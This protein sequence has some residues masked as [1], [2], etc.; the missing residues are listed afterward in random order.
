[1]CQ[2]GVDQCQ[3]PPANRVGRL[4]CNIRKHHCFPRF[5]VR[6]A[7]FI[8]KLLWDKPFHFIIPSAFCRL[9]AAT[10]IM[11]Y[12]PGFNSIQPISCFLV[13]KKVTY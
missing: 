4:L 1:L 2:S 9:N 12:A 7:D 5:D 3:C 13:V 11:I 10:S 6:T 8:F